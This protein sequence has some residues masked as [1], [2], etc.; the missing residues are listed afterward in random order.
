MEYLYEVTEMEQFSYTYMDD[1]YQT[2]KILIIYYQT[3]VNGIW[4]M[5]MKDKSRLQAAE[6]WFQV[7]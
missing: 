1:I 5:I 4:K 6:M 3:C 2:R 7:S